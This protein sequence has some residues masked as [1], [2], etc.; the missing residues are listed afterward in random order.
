MK[1][2]LIIYHFLSYMNNYYY[3]IKFHTKYFLYYLFY[4]LM[5]GRKF[6]RKRQEKSIYICFIKKSKNKKNILISKGLF[7]N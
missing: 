1:H 5:L 7:S 2:T 6:F 3:S 4:A